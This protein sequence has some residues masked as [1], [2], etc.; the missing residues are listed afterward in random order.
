MNWGNILERA[1]W[2]FVQGTLG[3]L[4]TV[5]VADALTSLNVESLTALG[6]AALGGGTAALLSFIKTVAQER[7]AHLNGV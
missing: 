4:T 7:L 3:S 6:L 2:T 1:G 5:A